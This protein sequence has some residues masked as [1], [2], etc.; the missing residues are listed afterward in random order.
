VS[1]IQLKEFAKTGSVRQF[2][3]NNFFFNSAGL[4]GEKVLNFKF[5]T[6]NNYK[7]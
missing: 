3:L 1:G 6:L 7:L 5:L 2:E 4:E